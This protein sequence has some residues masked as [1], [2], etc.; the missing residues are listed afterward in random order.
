MISV[1]K[2][3][4]CWQHGVFPFR[5]IS[6]RL[7]PFCPSINKWHL[8]FFYP[9]FLMSHIL[10][11]RL[12]TSMYTFLVFVYS[13]LTTLAHLKLMMLF[14]E[15][16]IT[17]NRKKTRR[18]GRGKN[19]SYRVVADFGSCKSG[20][21]PSPAPDKFLA[22]FAPPTLFTVAT[23]LQTV[24]SWMC[25]INLCDLLLFQNAY[26]LCAT[27]YTL[28]CSVIQK[29]WCMYSVQWRNFKFRA[30]PARKSFGPPP[31]SDEPLPLHRHPITR[32]W[33]LQ[34]RGIMVC[35]HMLFCILGPLSLINVNGTGVG[36]VA[37]VSCYMNAWVY[38]WLR[39]EMKDRVHGF[40]SRGSQHV[41]WRH[42]RKKCTRD[43]IWI[44]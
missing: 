8:I 37:P 1:E 5:L 13:L 31:P 34:K 18:K 28:P 6:I 26:H 27:C 9:R 32:I 7:I 11:L 29:F 38:S 43:Q 35:I 40:V 44:Y 22:R 20:Q 41:S 10:L 42:K 4:T 17:Y 2:I 21:V 12:L 16:S 39:R 3:R 33:S 15:C 23:Q 14:D 24:G 19:V 30:P 36:L 25:N